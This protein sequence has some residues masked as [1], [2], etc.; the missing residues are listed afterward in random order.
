LPFTASELDLDEHPPGGLYWAE[1][2]VAA[3]IEPGR[4][5]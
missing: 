2:M 5:E 3:V 4:R 1:Y